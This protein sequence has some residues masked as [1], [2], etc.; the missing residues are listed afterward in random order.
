MEMEDPRCKI[1]A[2]EMDELRCRSPLNGVV[3]EMEDLR[4]EGLSNRMV[5]EI[6]DPRLGGTAIQMEDPRC[7]NLHL[8]WGLRYPIGHRQLR[9]RRGLRGRP[10]DNQSRGSRLHTFVSRITSAILLCDRHLWTS[11]HRETR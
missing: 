8:N 9:L 3:I 5:L 1:V 6:E 11:K 4:C 7:N 2:I 10:V